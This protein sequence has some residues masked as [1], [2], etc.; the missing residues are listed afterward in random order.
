MPEN[1]W[2]NHSQLRIVPS[3]ATFPKPL[4]L[5][6]KPTEAEMQ[7][8]WEL[9]T[10]NDGHGRVP[11][12][13]QY[14]KERKVESSRW[15]ASMKNTE[16]PMALINGVTDEL[17]GTATNEKWKELLPNHPLYLLENEVG[18]YPPLECPEEVLKLYFS[19]TNSLSEAP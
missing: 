6:P 15:I 9:M 19:F 8:Y 7:R 10:Y 14:L 17:I 16:V 4:G 5:I 11:E 18:H 1:G 3:R 12:V 13:I 2:R